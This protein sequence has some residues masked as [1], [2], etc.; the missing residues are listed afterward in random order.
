MELH[1]SLLHLH[2]SADSRPLL[3]QIMQ[4][5]FSSVFNKSAYRALSPHMPL[6]YWSFGAV[7]IHHAF[8]TNL[9]L[10]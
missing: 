8:P 3:P 9:G 1:C 6:F 10:F 7:S 4:E 2:I 5:F